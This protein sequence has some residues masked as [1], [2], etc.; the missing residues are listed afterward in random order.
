MHKEGGLPTSDWVEL[1]A[2]ERNVS[3]GILRGH[4]RRE[5]SHGLGLKLTVRGGTS[6]LRG[7][8]ASVP[9]AGAVA[10]AA[11]SFCEAAHPVK[12]AASCKSQRA[13]PN[14]A[15]HVFLNSTPPVSLRH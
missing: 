6:Y 1:V 2:P 10:A 15:D 7:A 13:V 3:V 14:I 12:P 4:H 9:T 11:R 5:F 8:G